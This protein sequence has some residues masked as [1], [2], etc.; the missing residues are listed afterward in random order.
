MTRK[1]VKLTNNG[2]RLTQ[3]WVIF[4]VKLP[5]FRVIVD[6]EW[7]LAPTDPFP[8]HADPGVVGC[9]RKE[10]FFFV[11]L[12]HNKHAFFVGALMGAKNNLLWGHVYPAPPPPPSCIY[13][14]EGCRPNGNNAIP[15]RIV[16]DPKEVCG[17]LNQL[18]LFRSQT[19]E[20][21]DGEPLRAALVVHS[22]FDK[23]WVVP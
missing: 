6:P 16:V 2:V 13:S 4:R 20:A 23:M 5:D 21:G 7:S 10:D 19:R 14:P 9:T 8:G 1:S 3:L 15:G 12:F 11:H 18:L 22:L 17:A